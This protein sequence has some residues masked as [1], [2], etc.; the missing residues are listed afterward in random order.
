VVRRW[1]TV[2]QDRRLA[3]RGLDSVI[4]FESSRIESDAQQQHRPTA[5][6]VDL[7]R[8]TTR[9]WGRAQEPGEAHQ[10]A[11]VKR[12]GIARNRR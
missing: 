8:A 11:G 2:A 10:V 9:D 12:G 3:Q 1:S 6:S 7:S 4:G 5:A